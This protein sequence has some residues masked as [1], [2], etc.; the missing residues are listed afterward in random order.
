M[1]TERLQPDA[2]RALARS[3]LTAAG[4]AGPVADS[5]ADALVL[6]ECDGQR[7]HG[8]SRLKA[9][10]D[11]VAS[12][13][14][15][16]DAWPQVTRPRPATLHVD[17]SHGF[18]YPAVDAAVDRLAELAPDQG[19]A[20]AAI[21]RSHHFGV[22]GHPVER[23][24]RSGLVALAFS[25]SPAAMAP[26][27]GTTPLFGT[28]PIAFAVPRQ[29]GDPVVVDLSLSKVARGKVNVAAQR[30]EA[31][32]DDW[33]LDADGR[34][35]ADPEAALAGSMRPAGDAKGA[36]LAFMVELLSVAFTAS[37]FGFEASS[38]F[39]ADGPPPGIGQML[40]AIAPDGF[41]SDAFAERLETLLA[42]MTAQDG[43]RLPG[44]RRFALRRAAEVEGLEVDA[45]LLAELRARAG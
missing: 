20:A 45:G 27:G 9:Y 40:L 26:W 17:A 28:N 4:A 36:A 33:A 2:A 12:G 19:L 11:Q 39:D 15:V 29:D 24:A 23:L 31:I 1:T 25:N 22:A 14:V 43:V 44:Q 38:F 30:G 8:L 16:G 18:A 37:N 35:T 21:G 32:P 3:V 5:V 34:P 42:A 7:G 6:A 13:K 41:G 10:A